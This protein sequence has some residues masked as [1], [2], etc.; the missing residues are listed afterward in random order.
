MRNDSIIKRISGARRKFRACDTSL[1]KT[2][3]RSGGWIGRRSAVQ[4]SSAGSSCASDADRG[5]KWDRDA[6]SR[7]HSVNCQH[8]RSVAQSRQSDISWLIIIPQNELLLQSLGSVGWTRIRWNR[9][10]NLT[11]WNKSEWACLMLP[12][13]YYISVVLWCHSQTRGKATWRRDWQERE[14]HE[15]HLGFVWYMLVHV[16]F[17]CTRTNLK[18]AK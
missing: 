9:L 17:Y 14:D 18:Q 2:E 8:C 13:R 16:D 12:G 11:N 5:S 7:A 4:V 3:L 10:R 15:L 1:E 6:V